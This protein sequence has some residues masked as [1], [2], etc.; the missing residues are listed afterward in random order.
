MSRSYV[1]VNCVSPKLIGNSIL[2]YRNSEN[3]KKKFVPW[4]PRVGP[5]YQVRRV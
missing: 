3:K 4:S 1:Y 2:L 5:E